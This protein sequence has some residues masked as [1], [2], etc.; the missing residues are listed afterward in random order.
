LGLP[1]TEFSEKISP[2]PGEG[3]QSK[4]S[5]QRGASQEISA[6]DDIGS[7]LREPTVSP[8]HL[9]TRAATPWL[10]PKQSPKDR[11][12]FPIDLLHNSGGRHVSIGWR[13][14]AF[15]HDGR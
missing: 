10:S 15:K 6:P 9:A 1:P 7:S 11:F 13:E 14:P 5:V 8:L 3:N 2:V 4:A 12:G